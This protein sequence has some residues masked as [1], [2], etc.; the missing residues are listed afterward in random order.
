MEPQIFLLQCY[1]KRKPFC[2]HDLSGREEE[3]AQL[4]SILWLL[5]VSVSAG[6]ANNFA[7]IERNLHEV[8][9]HPGGAGERGVYPGPHPYAPERNKASC[10]GCRLYQAFVHT[11]ENER[12][13]EPFILMSNVTTD[14]KKSGSHKI[15]NLQN[16]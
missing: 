1:K 6:T 4:A 5:V 13:I 10:A 11:G 3:R 12:I 16:T 9:H 14:E 15:F 8:V 2:E 7:D